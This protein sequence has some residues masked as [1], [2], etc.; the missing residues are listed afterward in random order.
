MRWYFNDNKPSS[1]KEY[2]SS[3]S[4]P[5]KISKKAQKRIEEVKRLN[6]KK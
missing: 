6:K 4:E 5:E 3:L 2:R 1:W